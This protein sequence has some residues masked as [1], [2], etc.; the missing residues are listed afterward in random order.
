MRKITPWIPW[1]VFSVLLAAAAVAARPIADS[2]FPSDSAQPQA[3]LLMDASGGDL[4][5]MLPGKVEA[6]FVDPSNLEVTNESKLLKLINAQRTK[7]GIKKLALNTKLSRA[8]EK[9]SVDMATK[10]FFS[11]TGSTGSSMTA[12]IEAAGYKWSAAG[13]TLYAGSGTYNTPAQCV[14]AWLNSAGH[15]QIMLSKTYTQV[16]LGYYFKSGSPYGGYYTADFGKPR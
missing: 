13:E 10:G 5:Q 8:A 14:K 3:A 11:H 15:R 16:G 4:A 2:I 12:R 1:L 7:Y 6:A 9:H